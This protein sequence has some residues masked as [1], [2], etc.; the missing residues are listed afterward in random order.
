MYS[1][2][3]QYNNLL[4]QYVIYDSFHWHANAIGVFEFVSWK[5]NKI[6]VAEL[7]KK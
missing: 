4:D 1:V 7:N 3:N 5:T 2:I 6:T